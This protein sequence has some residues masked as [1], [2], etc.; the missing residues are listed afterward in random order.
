[1]GVRADARIAA[2]A[3]I[4]T[5]TLDVAYQHE[6]I[7]RRDLTAAFASAPSLTFVVDGA[8]PGA[9]G[10]R[11]A[12]G[13]DAQVASAVHLYGQVRRDQFSQSDATSWVAGLDV[14][15]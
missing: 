12:L 2:G 8:A 6:L 9:D 15:W 5:P 11:I 7:D 1:V 14:V 3:V 4:F 10:A 13:I